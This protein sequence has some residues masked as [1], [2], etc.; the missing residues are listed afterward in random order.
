MPEAFASGADRRGIARFS[1]VSFGSG[2]ERD[3]PVGVEAPLFLPALAHHRGFISA[4]ERI[5]RN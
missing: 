4:H 2:N 5:A 1:A 3:L